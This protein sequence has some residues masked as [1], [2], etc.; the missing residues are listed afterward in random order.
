MAGSIN[1]QPSLRCDVCI[2]LCEH[3][4]TQAAHAK[5]TKDERIFL[6]ISYL[7]NNAD[8]AMIFAEFA[9]YFQN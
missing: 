3:W 4:K 2:V 5:Y 1:V 6:L 9:K 8:Y 7:C